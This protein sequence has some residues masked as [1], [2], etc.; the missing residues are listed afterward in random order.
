MRLFKRQASD[1]CPQ[2]VSATPISQDET[3]ETV[4]ANGTTIEQNEKSLVVD[5]KDSSK[6]LDRDGG[7]SGESEKS[8]PGQSFMITRKGINLKRNRK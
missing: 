2:L 7:E 5:K 4:V 8:V 1:T 6:R 3:S